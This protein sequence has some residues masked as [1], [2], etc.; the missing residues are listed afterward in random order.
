MSDLSDH[1]KT[2]HEQRPWS[3]PEDIQC[4][5]FGHGTNQQLLRCS[6]SEGHAGPH[7][8]TDSSLAFGA[9]RK[10]ESQ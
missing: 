1:A 7:F 8:D 5:E 4:P 6:L 9:N 2:V 3:V 10:Q